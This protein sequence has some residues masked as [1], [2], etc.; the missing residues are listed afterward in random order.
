MADWTVSGAETAAANGDYSENGVW[1]GKPAFEKD[2][3]GAWI[4]W[5]SGFSVWCIYIFRTSDDRWYYGTGADLPANPWAKSLGDD[6]AP[7]VEA[8]VSGQTYNHFS[9]ADLVIEPGG[10]SRG[11][12]HNTN[13]GLLIFDGGEVLRGPWHNTDGGQLIMT[14]GG[15][16][17]I[18]RGKS[19]STTEWDFTRGMRRAE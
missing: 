2:G 15:L 14:P 5:H 1:D 6:P 10:L 19:T 9:G 12:W 8:G 3:G 17:T 16:N 13:G 18:E 4:F 11:P 7:T